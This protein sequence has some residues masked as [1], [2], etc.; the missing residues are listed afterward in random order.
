MPVLPV[1]PA[2]P[3]RVGVP[4]ISL[5]SLM[6]L[7]SL[8]PMVRSV[9]DGAKPPTAQGPF[10]LAPELVA[11]RFDM[12]TAAAERRDALLAPA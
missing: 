2:L 12:L 5:V 1:L 7:V 4:L 8:G 9:V 10:R 3:A 11:A 6:P